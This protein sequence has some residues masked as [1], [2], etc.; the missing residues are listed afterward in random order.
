MPVAFIT[1]A[2]NGIGAGLA[3]RLGEMG[4]RVALVDVD[5]DSAQTVAE[6]IGETALPLGADITDMASLE[7]AVHATVQ[8]FG[9]IDL[10]VA[11]AGFA[12][13]GSLRH[14]D[15]DAFDAQ[16][17]VNLG[18]TYRTVRACLP[19]LEESKGYLVINAS[20]SA[21]QAPPGLGAYGA[22]KA[23]IETLADVLRIE[24]ADLGID[25]GVAYFAWIGTDLLTG[26]EREQPA[27][28]VLRESMRWPLKKVIPVDEAVEALVRGIGR[29]SD[30][31]MAPGVVRPLYRLR[32]IL[33]PLVAPQLRKV[34]PDI[35]A[36]TVEA[37]AEKGLGGVIRDTAAGEAA[38]RSVGRRV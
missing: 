29:R 3:R 17:R 38:A 16:I 31:I 6:E 5:H 19:A 26:G 2:G 13:A 23:A 28:R 14:L 8:R 25:V 11:N 20:L 15:L 32:G 35:D 1:G 24:L 12:T 34:A 18:G 30:R 21:I 9:G 7:S 10:A 36:A 37:I 4:Y 33:G 27:F 22:S